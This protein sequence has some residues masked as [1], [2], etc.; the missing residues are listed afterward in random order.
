MLKRL[1]KSSYAED[2]KLANLILPLENFDDL[3]RKESKTLSIK[4]DYV[5]KQEIDRSTLYSVN[6]PFQLVHA[7]I[8]NLRFLGKSVTHPKYCLVT[9]DVYSSKLYAYSMRQRNLLTKKLQ[10]F[11]NDIQS[12]RKKNKM[13][14]Q[15]DLEFQ[16]NDIKELNKKYNVAMFPTKIRR[17]K[18][19][20][21]GQKTGELKKRILKLRLI[22]SKSANLHQ[23][24]KMSVDN[25]NKTNSSK[26]GLSPDE[27][28]KCSSSS[29][30]FR[31]GFKFDQIKTVSRVHNALDKYD[32]KNIFVKKKT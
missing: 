8:A 17:G 6:G 4:L 13:R 24:I 18:A 16:K 31:L 2:K 32:A 28:E 3:N 15:V 29:E 12:K 25:I 10:L 1:K 21:A 19:F 11:Y 5:E 26:Y 27:I 23:L 20:A 9:V 22:K 7:D 30:K 14:L